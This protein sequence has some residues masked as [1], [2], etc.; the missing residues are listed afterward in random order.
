MRR[1]LLRER[2]WRKW[3]TVALALTWT[4]LGF[5]VKLLLPYAV[6]GMVR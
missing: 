1:E 2:K 3:L 6:R 4:A 5:I